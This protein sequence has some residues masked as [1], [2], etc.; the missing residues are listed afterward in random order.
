MIGRYVYGRAELIDARSRAQ[1]KRLVDEPLRQLPVLN[2][3]RH[4]FART[5][6]PISS[7]A[8]RPTTSRS[9]RLIGSLRSCRA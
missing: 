9:R 2:L 1:K 8:C 4:H 5:P 7:R 3:E 6:L